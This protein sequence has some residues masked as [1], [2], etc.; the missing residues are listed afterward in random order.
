MTRITDDT[1][2]VDHNVYILG[3]GFSAD[4]GIPV[5][6]GFL[7]QMIAGLSWL[8]EQGRDCETQA[9]RD[10]LEFREK[11]ASA[12]LRVKLNL[13]N[14]EDLIQPGCGIWSVSARTECLDRHRRNARFFT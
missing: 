12:G 3:A 4:A 5:P 9:I 1:K 8:S 10:V 7:F 13:D 11:A 14:I 2:V 6:D